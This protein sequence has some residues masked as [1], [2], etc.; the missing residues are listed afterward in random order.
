MG[1]QGNYSFIRVVRAEHR[2]ER[3]DCALR[4][5]TCSR[6]RHNVVSSLWL[7]ACDGCQLVETAGFAR[8]ELH[9]SRQTS[10]H[11]RNNVSEDSRPS[12][13][14]RDDC[15]PLWIHGLGP[16][17][18]HHPTRHDDL[19]NACPQRVR[20]SIE[21]GRQEHHEIVQRTLSRDRSVR[22]SSLADRSSIKSCPLSTPLELIWGPRTR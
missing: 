17:Q 1:C 15:G 10:A 20:T 21:L 8:N 14:E 12:P 18:W 5:E 2:R 6:G 3:R 11:A 13:L 16:P 4:H 9:P 22:R 7:T 19:P